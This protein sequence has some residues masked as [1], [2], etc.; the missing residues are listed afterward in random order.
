MRLFEAAGLPPGVINMVTGDGHAVSEVALTHRMLAGIHFTGSTPTFQQ[1]WRTVGN[2]IAS[3]ACYPRLVGETGGKDF[4]IAHPSADPAALVTGLVR[5]AFEYQ[6]Q[7]CSAASRAYVPRSLWAGGLRD[8]LAAVTDSLSFGDVT[9]FANFG[10]A[11]IDRRAFDRLSAVQDRLRAE[12]SATVIAGGKSDDSIGY[13]VQPTVVE[14]SD[15]EHEVFRTEYFGPLLAV[16]VYDDANWADTLTQLESV[17]PYA[18]TG[19]VFARDR[20]AILEASQV[21]RF[22]AGNFYVNDKPTGAV[23]GQQ[24]FGGARSSGTNDKAGSVWNLLRWA[25]PRSIK[26]TFVAAT[27]HRYPHMD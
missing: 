19:A 27:D 8:E 18:L 13:F 24:P 1:L 3:Y 10:G 20:A 7:K 6:G 23:V 25:S 15:P 4:V 11:V 16:H 14:S 17:S 9:D 12:T 22:A 26:E 5:G 2:S 21:L